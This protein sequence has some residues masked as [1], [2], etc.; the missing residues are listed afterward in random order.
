M[1]SQ[2]CEYYFKRQLFEDFS[3]SLFEVEGGSTDST[4][5]YRVFKY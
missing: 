4:A 2:Y 5:L 1:D 3:S